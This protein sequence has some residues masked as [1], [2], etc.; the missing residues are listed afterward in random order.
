MKNPL[1]F[2]YLTLIDC[3]SYILKKRDSDMSSIC[4][5][6]YLSLS[7]NHQR[8]NCNLIIDTVDRPNTLKGTFDENLNQ[9]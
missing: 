1:S 6:V 4:I 7:F 2:V 9:S 8:T 3:L 5:Q